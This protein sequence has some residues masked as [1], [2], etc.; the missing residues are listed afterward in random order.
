MLRGSLP[1]PRGSPLHTRPASERAVSVPPDRDQAADE[2]AGTGD[3][4]QHPRDLPGGHLAAAGR[5]QADRPDQHDARPRPCRQPCPRA[6]L[7]PA[8]LIQRQA[9]RR[10]QPRGAI[11]RA[12][13]APSPPPGPSR[14]VRTRPGSRR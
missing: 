11:A 10:R 4:V 6:R 9:A 3:P 7:V 8:A 13:P 12:A 2:G 1:Q 14:T 5:V